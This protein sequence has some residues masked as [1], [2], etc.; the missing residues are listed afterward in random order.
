MIK[1]F[2]ATAI[3]SKKSED[4]SGRLN[5]REKLEIENFRGRQIGRLHKDRRYNN[6]IKKNIISDFVVQKNF[7]NLFSSSSVFLFLR[8]NS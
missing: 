7:N 1:T 6:Q 2:T 3:K 4:E 8:I 5:I